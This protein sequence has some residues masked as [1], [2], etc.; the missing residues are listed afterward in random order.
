MASPKILSLALA[1]AFAVVAL[2]ATVADAKGA[3]KKASGDLLSGFDKFDKNNDGVITLAET[4]AFYKKKPKRLK[5][6]G[7]IFGRWDKDGD[8]EVTKEEYKAYA[9]SKRSGGSSSKKKKPAEDA[10]EEESASEDE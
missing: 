5:K 10:A 7:A 2:P 1:L 4:K 8:G 9:A 3:D 6:A